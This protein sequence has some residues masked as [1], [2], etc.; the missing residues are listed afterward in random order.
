VLP[1]IAGEDIG[2]FADEAKGY[3]AADTGIGR[4]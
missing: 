1:E 4:R 2:P 3:R